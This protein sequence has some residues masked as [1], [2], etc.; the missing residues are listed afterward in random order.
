[1][2]NSH[3]QLNTEK[4][5]I[6]TYDTAQHGIEVGA[7]FDFRGRLFEVTSVVPGQVKIDDMR[8]WLKGPGFHITARQLSIPLP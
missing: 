4:L 1:M 3:P 7:K 2:T 6:L 5:P 8:P